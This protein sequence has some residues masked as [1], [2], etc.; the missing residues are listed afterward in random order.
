MPASVS[1]KKGNNWVFNRTGGKM[2]LTG[3]YTVVYDEGYYD[4]VEQEAIYASFA[5]GGGVTVPQYGQTCDVA[6]WEW[7]FVTEKTV[8]QTHPHYF[9]VTITY[10]NAGIN[11][12]DQ[13]LPQDP[14]LL[15]PPISFFT[16]SGQEIADK[17]KDDNAIRNSSKEPPDP[18]LMEDDLW[19]GMRL[20]K[21]YRRGEYDP[22]DYAN[23]KRS[24][25]SSTL[26]IRAK[27]GIYTFDANTVKLVEENMEE[28]QVG[29]EM[30]CEVKRVFHIRAD[31]LKWKRR[32]LDE[33]Y[34]VL[35]GSNIKP[36]GESTGAQR[37]VTKELTNPD[38]EYN[39][40]TNPYIFTP[41]S[42]PTLLNGSGALLA[43]N[44]SPVYL[45]KETL[46]PVSYSG[47][48]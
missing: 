31:E 15:L 36:A 16:V 9:I 12:P 23:Y 3:D 13:P 39:A 7:L 18:P 10:T 2:T 6:N 8:K 34:S 20:T 19:M 45:Q 25:N 28:I 29:Q 30:F 43:H 32:L 1:V 41:A 40:E 47:L 37:I 22:K 35:T 44:G 4:S 21:Y 14:T 5:N 46:T 17:D 42:E 33:G 24:T 38:E 26:T 27:S 11:N 48:V